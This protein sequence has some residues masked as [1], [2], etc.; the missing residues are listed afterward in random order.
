MEQT[1]SR[2]SPGSS[3][4]ASAE[5]LEEAESSFDSEGEVP[6]FL[7]LSCTPPLLIYLVVSRGRGRGDRVWELSE[8][9]I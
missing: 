9:L 4:S 2:R 7:I 3:S 5:E 6:F 8:V 1:Q